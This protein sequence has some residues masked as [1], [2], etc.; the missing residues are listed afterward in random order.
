M[1]LGQEFGS[2]SGSSKGKQKCPKQKRSTDTSGLL[3]G[4]Q[5][6]LQQIITSLDGTPAPSIP[7]TPSPTLVFLPV[8]ACAAATGGI[9]PDCQSSFNPEAWRAQRSPAGGRS[10]SVPGFTGA[11]LLCRADSF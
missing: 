6:T 1:R 11:A 10:Q 7:L 5:K 2:L 8:A 3:M 4:E 9:A